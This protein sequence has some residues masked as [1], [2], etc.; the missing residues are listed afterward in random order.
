MFVRLPTGVHV[1]D[2]GFDCEWT[3]AEDASLLRGVF[4]YGAG[5][6]DAIRMDPELKLSEVRYCYILPLTDSRVRN[7]LAFVLQFITGILYGNDSLVKK[8]V[9]T[10]VAVLFYLPSFLSCNL[11]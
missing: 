6:W 11:L 8:N 10:A 7:T 4:K 9:A 5:N 2:A 3:D 1:K